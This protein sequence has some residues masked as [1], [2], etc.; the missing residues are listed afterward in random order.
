MIK[1][2]SLIRINLQL[3][4]GDS[5]DKTEKATPKKR[6]DA[7]RRGQILKSQEIT[8]AVILLLVF[9]VIRISGGYIYRKLAAY[10]EE[11]IVE[12]SKIDDLFVIDTISKYFAKT[13]VQTF[14]I[15]APIL[16]AA[17][18]GAVVMEYAQV[19]F[20]LTSKTLGFK[21]S[22]LNPINGIKRVFSLR[23]VVELV[24]ALLKICIVGY[25]AY[26]FIRGEATNII[27]VMSMDLKGVVQYLAVTSLNL[28]IR[29]CVMLVILGLFDYGYQWWQYER[30]MKM[31]KQEVKEEYKMMEGN[32]EIKSKIKQKQRQ[33]SMRRMLQEVPKADVII[34]NPTHYAVALKYDP[35]ESNAPVVVAKGVDFIAARIKEVAKE[36]SIEIV[37][38]KVLARTLYEKV[39]IGET[40]PQEL[41]Q[42]VAEVLAFVYSLKNKTVT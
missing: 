27:N 33:I 8:S 30:E 34:T 20:L 17:F 14:M 39:D 35:K 41:Y 13:I 6:R 40:I 10:T 36:N 23:G 12:Y 22:R 28:A 15:L 31:T 32:P 21:F 16:A 26:S 37:E 11:V 18:A 19:G 42:A 5:G 1:E 25:V 38:N 29:L 7:R 3:F 2:N 24:K 9:V 4:A